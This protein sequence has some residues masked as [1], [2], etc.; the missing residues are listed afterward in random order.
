MAARLSHPRINSRVP[1]LRGGPVPLPPA[2]SS[3]PAWVKRAPGAFGTRRLLPHGQFIILHTFIALPR[4]AILNLTDIK[5]CCCL[6]IV[7]SPS[8]SPCCSTPPSAQGR[9]NFGPALPRLCSSSRCRGHEAL[10]APSP[11]QSRRLARS[12]VLV[13]RAQGAPRSCLRIA[14]A[15]PWL[16]GHKSGGVNLNDAG[17]ASNCSC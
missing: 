5:P 3:R 16:R 4:T 9:T 17:K 12:C 13:A 15:L 1:R 6:L 7:P 14:T 2:S 10:P 8:P 11:L